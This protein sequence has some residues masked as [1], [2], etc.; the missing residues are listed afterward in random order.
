MPEPSEMPLIYKCKKCAVVRRS[1]YLA[2]ALVA[3][4][5]LC[6]CE[7]DG[8]PQSGFPLSEESLTTAMERSGISWLISQEETY[9]GTEAHTSYVLRDPSEKY[10]S[11]SPT[12]R[13]RAAVSSALVEDE[14]LLQLI[15]DSSPV[16]TNYGKAPLVFSWEDWKQQL[17]F[18]AHLYGGFAD[19]NALYQAF[20]TQEVPTGEKSAAW[21]A[22]FPKAYCRVSYR[23]RGTQIVHT[24]PNPVELEQAA[25]L[26]VTIYE[27]EAL[28]HRLQ[29]EA[30]AK[31]KEPE[32]RRA[33]IPD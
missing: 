12:T 14:R 7:S 8:L 29:E 13:M 30:A 16:S 11:E 5:S 3:L 26:N 17:V 24:F 4:C 6:G 9:S 31:K 25:I 10:S 21:E 20:S 1:I 15:F 22:W 33:D 23:I 19:E 2:L 27:S 32:D 28:Y 18:A